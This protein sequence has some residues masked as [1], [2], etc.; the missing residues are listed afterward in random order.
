MFSASRI[1]VVPLVAAALIGSGSVNAGTVQGLV[2]DP[3]GKAIIG[4]EVQI[5]YSRA[6]GAFQKVK[7]DQNGQ[8]VFKNLSDG[9]SY[10]ITTWVNRAGTTIENVVPRAAGAIRIDFDI[11]AN[12]TAKKPRHYFYLQETTGSHLR[13][14]WVEVDEN[15]RLPASG[16]PIE[17][18]DGDHLR[19]LF[20]GASFGAQSGGTRMRH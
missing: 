6:Q 2:T 15:G 4:A 19:R 9:K 16:L 3:D 10:K 17:T 12:G 13:G 1:S 5:A 14:R 20:R 7:T 18:V 11:S 8:Y